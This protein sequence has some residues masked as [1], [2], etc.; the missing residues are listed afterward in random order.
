MLCRGRKKKRYG[1]WSKFFEFSISS[2]MCCLKEY[3]RIIGFMLF[4]KIMWHS[5]FSADFPLMTLHELIYVSRILKGTSFLMLQ[6]TSK[7]DLLI[8]FVHIK[9][10]IHNYYENLV[11]T[12]VELALAIRMEIIVP[13]SLLKRKADMKHYV[14]GEI[15]LKP[16]GIVFVGRIRNETTQSSYSKPVM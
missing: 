7:E 5:I 2:R 15:C 12:D 6:L 1:L 14:D 4:E 9:L 3:R 16:L 8:R 10:S 11:L 13:Q